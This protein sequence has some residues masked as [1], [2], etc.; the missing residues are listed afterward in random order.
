METMK[1]SSK[2]NRNL[3]GILRSVVCAVAAHIGCLAPP[4]AAQDP[5]DPPAQVEP[6][7]ASA[8]SADL[9]ISKLQVS[10]RPK[11]KATLVKDLENWLGA[12]QQHIVKVGEIELQLMDLGEDEEAAADLGAD[13]IDLRTEEVELVERTKVVAA[14]L[15]A[16]G[17]GGRGQSVH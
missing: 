1:S 4:A 10:L 17:G 13:L 11:A 15:E 5:P 3:A 7:D 14:A 16:K 8:P 9:P 6:T 2:I 12:L